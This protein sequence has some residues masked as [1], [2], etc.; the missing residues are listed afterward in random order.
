MR[1]CY[2]SDRAGLIAWTV[3][4]RH[5]SLSEL[6]TKCCWGSCQPLKCV[7]GHVAIW[8]SGGS[9]PAGGKPHR[10]RRAVADRRS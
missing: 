10:A 6:D 5:F 2:R 7:I 1:S 8:N 3:L 9:C 4:A